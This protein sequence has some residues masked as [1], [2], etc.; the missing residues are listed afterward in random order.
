MHAIDMTTGTA[1]VAFTGETPWHGLG[2][3]MGTNQDMGDWRKRAGLNWEAVAAPVEY[4]VPGTGLLQVANRKVL[5][6]SD[7]QNALAVVSDRYQIVQPADVIDFYSQLCNKYDFTMETA[8]AL[9][10]G[11]VIW[12]LAKTGESTRITGTDELKGYVLLST[13]FDG[14]MATTVRH[15]SVRV[16]CNNTLQ[17]SNRDGAS[18]SVNHNAMFDQSRAI[19]ALGI[20][21]GWVDFTNDVQRMAEKG[22]TPEQSVAFFMSVYHNLVAGEQTMTAAQEKTVAKTVKRLTDQLFFAP[23]ADL[24]SSKGTAW[25]L[26]N[27]VTHDIDFSRKARSQDSRLASAWYGQGSLIKQKA[28]EAASALAA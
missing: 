17:M 24:K 12:A 25:G 9:K 13:S 11:R 26:V 21:E 18:L 16:V 28:W 15:T 19:K 4:L 1:A 8:G 5:Y 7:T 23:G 27:A 20:G 2:A 10:D 22:V 14:T 6:R 3:D